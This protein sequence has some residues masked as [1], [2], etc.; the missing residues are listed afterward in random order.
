MKTFFIVLVLVVVLGAGYL[1]LKPDNENPVIIQP[2]QVEEPARVATLTIEPTNT[3]LTP[4][5]SQEFK[6]IVDTSE[7]SVDGVDALLKFDPEFLE[8]IDKFDTSNSVFSSFPLNTIDAEQGTAT[9]SA[10][11]DPGT[12]FTGSGEV[13][14][15]T[16]SASKATDSN[17]HLTLFFAPGETTDSN[18]ASQGYDILGS[19]TNAALTIN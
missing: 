9:L 19:V 1:A 14:R 11:V 10:L 12:T 7:A 18:V 15:F 8:L 4:N 3:Q 6:I 2:P 17:V 5:E 13:A 16:A